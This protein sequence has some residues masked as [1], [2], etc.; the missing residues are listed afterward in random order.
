M[1]K[2]ADNLEQEKQQLGKLTSSELKQAS[3]ITA[4]SA[5][6][7]RQCKGAIKF[8]RLSNNLML[9]KLCCKYR[10]F[11]L[12]QRVLSVYN[13]LNIKTLKLLNG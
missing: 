7:H 11:Y 3:H 9:L 6:Q 12:K 5:S 13:R 10:A 8:I 1:V 2:L 4:P